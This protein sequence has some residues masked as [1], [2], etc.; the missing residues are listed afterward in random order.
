MVHSN[1]L[2]GHPKRRSLCSCGGC[3][4]LIVPRLIAPFVGGEIYF[5]QSTRYGTSCG[6]AQTP[7]S[8]LRI[9]R[10]MHRQL[11]VVDSDKLGVQQHQ[12]NRRLVLQKRQRL[13]RGIPSVC[14]YR[15]IV[16]DY[17][18]KRQQR[19]VGHKC[20]LKRTAAPEVTRNFERS[21]SSEEIPENIAAIPSIDTFKRN[22]KEY[23]TIQW[24]IG[25]W[26]SMLQERLEELEQGA[27]STKESGYYSSPEPT[28]DEMEDKKSGDKGTPKKAF[29]VSGEKCVVS[30]CEDETTATN[31]SLPGHNEENEVPLEDAVTTNRTTTPCTPVKDTT[32][33]EDVAGD[34]ALEKIVPM[35][36]VTPNRTPLSTPGKESQKDESP[37]PSYSLLHTSKSGILDPSYTC[38]IELEPLENRKSSIVDSLLNKFN[39]SPPVKQSV[40]LLSGSFDS[41]CSEGESG[42]STRRL[43]RD[44]KKIAARPRYIEIPEEPR[45]VRVSKV[46]GQLHKTLN[47]DLECTN[48]NSSTEFYGFDEGEVVKLD[49]PSLPGLLPTPIVKKTQPFA[50][51]LSYGTTIN[52]TD[53][54]GASSETRSDLFH[55]EG[56]ISFGSLPPRLSCP[57]RP[58]DMVRPRTVAQKRILLQKE[59]DVRY[60]MIDNESKIFH[61][62]EKRTKN[63]DVA[64]DFQRMKE[65]QDQPIPFTRDTWRALSWLRTEK[66]RYYFQT[67]H[68]DNRTV[69]LAGCQ[70]NHP[71]RRLTRKSTFSSPVVAS[72]GCRIHYITNCRCPEYPENIVLDIPQLTSSEQQRTGGSHVK[73]SSHSQRPKLLPDGLF[74]P[75]GDY[76]THRSY[77]HLK[78]GPLSSKCLQVDTLDDPYLGPREIFQMPPVELEVFPKIN[79]PLD[80]YVKPYLKMILPHKGITENWA[81]FAVSTLRPPMAS[82]G[83]SIGKHHTGEERSFVFQLPYENNQRRMLIRRRLIVRPGTT[84][85]S[86]VDMDIEKFE[87]LMQEKLIFRKSID[88]AVEAH[89]DV[90]ADERICADILSEMTD[91]VAIALAEDI[92]QRDDPDVDYTKEETPLDQEEV[93]H[94]KPVAMALAAKSERTTPIPT[95][96]P[97]SSAGASS[98]ISSAPTEPPKDTSAGSVANQPSV[99]SECSKTNDPAKLKLLREMKRLNATIIEGPSQP[100]VTIGEAAP[101]RQQCD[102]QYCAHGCICD[103]LSGSDMCV[104]VSRLRK[105]RCRQIDC[106][107]GCKC[108][109]EQKQA[110][111]YTKTEAKSEDKSALFNADMKHLHEEVTERLAKEERQFTSTVI[112][113]GDATVV[114]PNSESETRRQKKMP[115]KFN[116]YYDDQS[117]QCLLKGGTAVEPMSFVTS[118]PPANVKPLT[119]AERMRHAH[120]VLNRIPELANLE[121]WCMVHELYRCFCG[122][123][124]TQGKPFS[125]TEDNYIALSA[126]KASATGEAASG[127]SSKAVN[128]TPLPVTASRMMK[129]VTP[130]LASSKTTNNSKV[131]PL[132]EYPPEVLYETRRKRLYSF[133]KPYTETEHQRG[134][135]VGGRM[136]RATGNNSGDGTFTLP[137]PRRRERDSSEE[138]YKPPSE[139][140]S[141]KAK[142]AKFATEGRRASVAVRRRD[143]VV[144]SRLTLP[145]RRA[146]IAAREKA[147]FFAYQDEEPLPPPPS[148]PLKALRRSESSMVAPKTP[149]DVQYTVVSQ[150]TKNSTGKAGI[151]NIIIKRIPPV[152]LQSSQPKAVQK[153]TTLLVGGKERPFRMTV[154]E[155]RRII[156]QEH[157][158]AQKTK[159]TKGAEQ[160]SGRP[161]AEFCYIDLVDSEENIDRVVQ[162]HLNNLTDGTKK[163]VICGNKRTY[164]ENGEFRDGRPP[165]RTIPFNDRTTYI[166]Q[167]PQEQQSQPIPENDRSVPKLAP[168]MVRS[169][170][171]NQPSPAVA[172][173]SKPPSTSSSTSTSTKLPAPPPPQL[174]ETAL[175][176][177]AM[178][179]ADRELVKLMRHINELIGKDKL[180]VTYPAKHGIMYICRWKVFLRAFVLSQIDVLDVVLKNGVELTLVRGDAEQSWR[181]PPET[182]QTTLSARRSSC[183]GFAN[184]SADEPNQHPRPSLLLQM[185]IQRVDNVKTNQLALVLYGSESYWHFCGFIKTGPGRP[186]LTNNNILLQPSTQAKEIVKAR[187][188]EYY[189]RSMAATTNKPNQEGAVTQAVGKQIVHGEGR[190]AGSSSPPEV[191]N[192]EIVKRVHLCTIYLER[193]LIDIA[194]TRTPKDSVYP[195]WMS[196]TIARDFSNLLIPSLNCNVSYG[197]L[198]NLMKK[199]NDT[200][201]PIVFPFPEV[202]IAPS[203]GGKQMFRPSIFCL[204]KQEGMIFIG[205]FPETDIKLDV[206]LCQM[207][208]GKMYTREEFQRMNSIDVAGK[209]RTQGTWLQTHRPEVHIQ[210]AA[211]ATPSS[212]GSGIPEQVRQRSL[213]KRNVSH[214]LQQVNTDCIVVLDDD[215]EE[216]EQANGNGDDVVEES[217]LV[218]NAED[219]FPGRTTKQPHTNATTME[220]VN[221]AEDMVSR[222]RTQLL[223]LNSNQ[224]IAGRRAS[225][226]VS[227]EKR[228]TQNVSESDQQRQNLMRLVEKTMEQTKEEKRKL[229]SLVK[230]TLAS[231]AQPLQ[232]KP[233]LVGDAAVTIGNKR[234]SIDCSREEPA[235]SQVKIMRRSAP[236]TVEDKPT[237]T[238]T[239]ANTVSSPSMGTRLP[240]RSNPIRISLPN[241]V[242]SSQ[243]Q[244]SKVQIFA[245]PMAQTTANGK[246]VPLANG[247]RNSTPT[248][249]GKVSPALGNG[250]LTVKPLEKLLPSSKVNAEKKRKEEEEEDVVCLDD[251]DED[252]PPTITTSQQSL[253]ATETTG[254]NERTI[255]SDEQIALFSSKL[256]LSKTCKAYRYNAAT[257]VLTMKRSLINKFAQQDPDLLRDT[258]AALGS[259]VGNTTTT[260][261]KRVTATATAPL[262]QEATIPST[263]MATPTTT[264]ELVPTNPKAMSSVM[265]MTQTTTSTSVSMNSPK[266]ST[267]TTAPMAPPEATTSVTRTASTK[268][269]STITP[270][271]QQATSAS[272]A[273]TSRRMSLPRTKVVPRV[274]ATPSPGPGDPTQTNANGDQS[275]SGGGGGS[276]Q[277][278]KPPYVILTPAMEAA[279]LKNPHRRGVLES[280]IPKLGLVEVIRL[281]HEVIVLVKE[282]TGGGQHIA[283]VNLEEAVTLLNRF[284]QFNTYTFKPYNLAI[285]WE[286]KERSKPLAPHEDL[287]KIINQRCVVTRYGLIDT[288]KAD[289]MKY[290][291]ITLPDLYDEL[292]VTALAMQSIPKKKYEEQRYY[293]D[294]EKVFNQS[295]VFIEELKSTNRALLLEKKELSVR[296]RENQTKLKRLSRG[297]PPGRN[298]GALA[299]TRTSSP[300]VISPNNRESVIVIDDD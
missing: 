270:S 128:G 96:P 14:A 97:L 263:M 155:L 90:D 138:S 220:D 239:T 222:I 184:S 248:G 43:L 275:S 198:L 277:P 141:S 235:D 236:M 147:S 118:E 189:R 63:I 87:K 65:L 262:E 180:N 136:S 103:V 148:V 94:S 82:D 56:L 213:L 292:M 69:K 255:L 267:A 71:H 3:C 157:A 20:S 113:T 64:L 152:P 266:A 77:P 2:G 41:G 274:P 226:F 158:S 228:S 54:A 146:S 10:L 298:N 130:T 216:A 217:D 99:S 38:D 283:V 197:R 46:F 227:S 81:R 276:G 271:V 72:G 279:R 259:K 182:V 51:F 168:S 102:P 191:S 169:K 215:E 19:R 78:P 214:G 49:K 232:R 144:T 12:R 300:A 163:L 1:I 242:F 251:E 204:P 116:D 125:F 243:G 278:Q 84:V 237:T 249:L 174:T 114:V 244:S 265:K 175:Y 133:E 18:R 126:S 59:N 252:S 240:H 229:A 143:S 21:V 179:Q 253:P 79:R 281:E 45:R 66:G 231:P 124:A 181:M 295:A 86:V 219:A 161:M 288:S 32:M 284:I 16:P 186:Y 115:V 297:L 93:V 165:A 156:Q 55:E 5:S 151:S 129:A 70:G 9:C 164:V 273:T 154:N 205:P 187:L 7:P 110:V 104:I 212:Q 31:G 234:K 257:R 73:S 224:K 6:G 192:L 48:S 272:L 286:F 218:D 247:L 293:E 291:E 172:A 254:D 80:G 268:L 207:V 47:I 176:K 245:K 28:H 256:D 33:V 61:F 25:L 89:E 225:V 211:N 183:T 287:T 15:T 62:L 17:F 202:P 194:R 23:C 289:Q 75:V 109:Y 88:H 223:T 92:F 171:T 83:V 203:G 27:D 260:A 296:V 76:R 67:F 42:G 60:H 199:A 121:P 131:Q 44:R 208:D 195:R 269:T 280:K 58:N 30:P 209:K 221:K 264:A 246:W 50:P 107:F 13:F 24:T 120:V 294:V 167:I 100:K 200:Q 210:I 201:K 241:Q 140:K 52:A 101:Q 150:P 95:P 250:T 178:N 98:Q 153:E 68:I 53:D 22:Y 149:A 39:L 177:Q 35:G 57:Q 290:M 299:A 173:A 230:S 85:S 188:R 132:E 11:P 285:Q 137:L 145:K 238:T 123:T 108:G 162:L 4:W 193:L 29:E 122:G 8:R 282:L 196:I 37:R 74:P 106:I 159:A 206:I 26:F 111:N 91:S 127:V 34:G 166:V 233:S 112:V 139:K 185:L 36:M 119:P 105:Q 160:L 190:S 117:F 134:E 142:K 170:P 258:I 261:T 40:G 135:S